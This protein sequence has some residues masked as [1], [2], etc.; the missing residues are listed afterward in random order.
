[1]TLQK[2]PRFILGEVGHSRKGVFHKEFDNKNAHQNLSQ[3]IFKRYLH[4]LLI[5]YTVST[6][7]DLDAKCSDE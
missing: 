4:K 7:F 6:C 5:F 1:M 3:I 2:M